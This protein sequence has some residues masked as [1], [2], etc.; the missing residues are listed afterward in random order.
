MTIGLTVTATTATTATFGFATMG[1]SGTV[2]LQISP[3]KDFQFCVCPTYTGIPRATPYTH[4]GLNQRARYFARARTRLGS[5]AAEP[6]SNV[7]GFRTADGTAQ[8][9]P[10]GGILIEPALIVTPE[11]ITGLNF[12]GAF[13]PVAGFAAD[14]M[15]RDAP[16]ACRAPGLLSAG[17]YNYILNFDRAG[18]Q[19]DT[20]ALL[21]TNFPEDTQISVRATDNPDYITGLV[22]ILAAQAFRASPNMPGRLGYH[23]LLRLAGMITQRYVRVDISSASMALAHIE[24]LVVGR[25]RVSKNFSTEKGEQPSTLTQLERRRSGIP[26]RQKG[27]PMRK[28]DFDLSAVSETQHETL[29]GDLH[30]Y[31]SE[32]VLVVP[33]TRGN[34]FLHDRILYGD[35]GGGR[36]IN[37]NSPIFT[38]NYTIDSLI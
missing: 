35:L 18:A 37:V 5:G 25:A 32:P 24:H 2:E 23:G 9:Y 11:D 17:V 21:N 14:N 7:V 30:L 27:H 6:W 1:A 28:V 26:D 31:Q 8:T 10:S 3:R 20:I 12:S 15:L 36:V 33:N 34:A 16:C 29:Y 38:R 4:A 22:S 19:I 13:G